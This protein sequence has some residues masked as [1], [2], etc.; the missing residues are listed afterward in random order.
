MKTVTFADW[1]L[2][3]QILVDSKP[4]DEET[5]K[6]CRILLEAF[7]TVSVGRRYGSVPRHH[8]R[9]HLQRTTNQDNAW[10]E[11]EIPEDAKDGIRELDRQAESQ[12]REKMDCDFLQAVQDTIRVRNQTYCSS[13]VYSQFPTNVSY[14]FSAEAI[15]RPHRKPV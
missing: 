3:S 7:L 1:C 14:L 5:W 15:C 2:R 9:N 8:L 13:L 12:R 6:A 4:E 11:L 10:P